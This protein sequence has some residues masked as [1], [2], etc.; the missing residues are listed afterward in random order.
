MTRTP[1]P[2]TLACLLLCTPALALDVERADVRAFIDELV[3]DHEFDAGE[4]RATLAA[5]ETQQS[6]LDAIARPAERTKSWREY[7]AIFITPERI[8]AGVKF[9]GENEARLQR[10]AGQTGVPAEMLA[11]IIG[12]ET[13][14]GARAGRYR[15]LDSL[16]TL[17]FDYPPRSRFFRSELTQLFLL[18]RDE[19]LAIEKAVGSYAGAMGAPQFMPSSYRAYAVDGDGDGRRDLFDNWDDVLASVA[20]YF[21]AHGWRSGE[22]VVA[23]ATLAGAGTHQPEDNRLSADSTVAGLKAAGVRFATDQ[24]AEA[25]AG[26]LAFDGEDGREYWAGFHNFYVITRYNRS[27]MYALAVYQLG[28]AIGD[29]VRA[30]RPEVP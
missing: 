23:R 20:N 19:S 7:R 8:A 25:P 17:A 3:R 4:L 18:A 10:I 27:T 24:P 16:A 1:V 13:Y 6:V 29:A 9:W 5:V 28:Q 12:V 21:T 14:F 11:G 15:L 26:L 2:A 30:S 22:A